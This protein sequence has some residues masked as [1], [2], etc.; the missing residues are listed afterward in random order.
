MGKATGKMSASKP[1]EA[2]VKKEEPKKAVKA[3]PAKKEEPKVSPEKSTI[4]ITI[5]EVPDACD[6]VVDGFKTKGK[7]GY[8][9]ATSNDC[10]QCGK[11]F[12]KALTACKANTEAEVVLATQKK[13]EKK[14]PKKREGG[15]EKTPFGRD[16]SSGAGKIDLLLLRKEGATMEEMKACR[17]AV[18]SHL[19]ALTKAGFF[20]TRKDGKY[21][22]SLTKPVEAK[23]E[24]KKAEPKKAEP[25]KAEEAP[26]K[27]EPKKK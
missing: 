3:A 11:D 12:P 20:I 23:A 14:A 9:D 15:G 21:Y 18:G 26:K 19:S 16:A 27:V 24:P 8:Y 22:G 6:A 5:V 17:G 1:K 25:K 10:K 2:E 7:V 4:T 13:A